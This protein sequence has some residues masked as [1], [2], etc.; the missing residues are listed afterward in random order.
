MSSKSPAEKP[1]SCGSIRMSVGFSEASEARTFCSVRMLT[2]CA[3]T[4]ST[5]WISF[6]RRQRRAEVDGD[7]DVGA[8][9]AGDVDRQVV[10]EPAVD[11]QLATD[12][13]RRD[14]ARHRHAGAHHRRQLA[15][16]EDDRLA[17][18][19]GRSRRRDRESAAGR[20]RG[21]RAGSPAGAARSRGRSP[22]WRPSAATARARRGRPRP[23]TAARGRRA[24]AGSPGPGAAASR[25]AGCASRS[26][27]ASS[28][29]RRSSVRS[30]R[31][32]RRSSPCWC[33]STQSIGTC[34]SCSTLMTPTWA[35]PRAPPPERT[36]Q[37]FGRASAADREGQRGESDEGDSTH[38]RGVPS[39]RRC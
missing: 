19:R 12:L 31:R 3:V 15:L 16:A 38:D 11:E 2:I 21:S 4:P 24:C 9:R 32:R 39:A 18:D 7:H 27:P 37:T 1:P 36:R 6:A 28:P 5:L 33:R 10:G 8:H 25:R 35:A 30:H 26:R 20:S 13:R 14:R 22:R 34:S 17:G 29:S 23:G